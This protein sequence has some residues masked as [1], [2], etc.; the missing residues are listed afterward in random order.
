MGL[1]RHDI[2]FL[3]H[4]KRLGADFERSCM[5][6]RLRFYGESKD[7]VACMEKHGYAI[8][9]MEEAARMDKYSEPLFHLLGAQQTESLDY[10]DY[11]G[12]TIIH[13]LNQPVPLH[14][15][16][17]FTCVVDGGTIEHV[18]NFPV[19]VKSCMESLK[20]GGHFLG[21]TPANNQM[22]HG[23]Y[24]FSPELIFRV[25]SEE[26]GFKVKQMLI[27][28]DAESG[29]TQEWYEVAD[30]K[31]VKSRVMLVNNRPVT[32]RFIAEK[33]AEVEIFKS[34]PQQS[35]Y[36][37]TWNRHTALVQNDAKASGGTIMY[38]IKKFVP[39]KLK[40]F[41]RNIINLWNKETITSRTLGEIDP[42]QFRKVEI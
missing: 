38:M 15:K 5:L 31:S 11:E 16:N 40:V 23:F 35:D 19:A 25:F 37:D 10:S 28:A 13:D 17:T 39:Y 27:A 9:G 33:T 7:L 12:A 20:V 4:A 42:K 24:Q 26:N 6:G 34:T 14:L 18:F 30:P 3:F 32:M 22:G 8:E 21:I 1:T 29:Q 36:V 2:D 41:V